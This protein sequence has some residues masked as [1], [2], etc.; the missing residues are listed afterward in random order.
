M[1]SNFSLCSFDHFCILINK[2]DR[3]CED[4][5]GGSGYS[6]IRWMSQLLTFIHIISDKK[7]FSCPVYF[8]FFV[9]I[10]YFILF[11]IGQAPEWIKLYNIVDFRNLIRECARIELLSA[12]FLSAFL[13]SDTSENAI[14]AIQMRSKWQMQFVFC[15]LL[16][17]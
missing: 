4:N 8:K 15:L 2:F 1:N 13:R 11:L 9:Y 16:K 7:Y 10:F 14:K 6:Y 5:F 3:P 17:I 12:I